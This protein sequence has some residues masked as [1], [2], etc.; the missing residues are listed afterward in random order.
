MSSHVSFTAAS[1]IQTP[2]RILLLATW[3]PGHYQKL[4]LQ[5]LTKQC[6]VPITARLGELRSY[7]AS[8]ERHNSGQQAASSRTSKALSSPNPNQNPPQPPPTTQTT[9]TANPPPQLSQKHTQ[10]P[11]ASPPRSLVPSKATKFTKHTL[12]QPTPL[13]PSR[14][15]S[16]QTPIQILLAT[17]DLA[18]VQNN[19]LTH[20]LLPSLTTKCSYP[21]RRAEKLKAPNNHHHHHQF[22]PPFPIS[23]PQWESNHLSFTAPT[24]RTQATC[25][26]PPS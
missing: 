21:T 3:H 24:I 1:L 22:P 14:S 8:G 13:S 17:C 18:T 15:L 2:I 10:P 9:T 7:D 16:L 5:R 6:S 26:T 11:Q 19:Q 4:C 20:H 12:T 25:T 23:K